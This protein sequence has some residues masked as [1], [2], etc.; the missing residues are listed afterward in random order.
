MKYFRKSVLFLLL[1]SILI[2][3]TVVYANDKKV[4]TQLPVDVEVVNETNDLS[5]FK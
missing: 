2:T 3:N 4:N 5:A 1:L